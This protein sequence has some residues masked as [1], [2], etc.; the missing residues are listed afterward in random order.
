MHAAGGRLPKDAV[1]TRTCDHF[2]IGTCDWGDKYCRY[3]HICCLCGARAHGYNRCPFRQPITITAQHTSGRPPIYGQREEAASTPPT[4]DRSLRH[5]RPVFCPKEQCNPR[6]DFGS[7]Q[8]LQCHLN[9]VHLNNDLFWCHVCGETG[10]VALGGIRYHVKVCHHNVN[11]LPI[12][13]KIEENLRKRGGVNY[14]I[15][16]VCRP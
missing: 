2:N 14:L 13:V 8:V 1:H 7:Y 11:P 10:P 6:Q 12:I 3:P 4:A 15:P 5:H 16:E 9:S